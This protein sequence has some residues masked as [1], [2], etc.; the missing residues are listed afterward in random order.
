[1][2]IEAPEDGCADPREGLAHR[3]VFHYTLRTV[4][5]NGKLIKDENTDISLHN[6]VN[7]ESEFDA[8]LHQ[9][10]LYDCMVRLYT[11]PPTSFAKMKNKLD[12]PQAL[13]AL[14]KEGKK[15]V[16]RN[17]NVV[18]RG[19]KKALA[20]RG[21]SVKGKGGKGAPRKSENRNESAK[22]KGGRV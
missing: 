1:M 4:H 10:S 2:R 12:N 21:E 5:K 20:A 11:S 16:Q 19:V 7:T 8:K 14:P 9:T 6:L 18:A 22:G 15:C 13:G 3:M 17:F